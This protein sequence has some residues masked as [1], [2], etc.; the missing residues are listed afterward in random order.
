MT[1]DSHAPQLAGSEK[2]PEGRTPWSPRPVRSVGAKASTM[3]S[4]A[5]SVIQTVRVGA[6]GGRLPHTTPTSGGVKPAKGRG[7][8]FALRGRASSSRKVR[9]SWHTSSTPT[10]NPS[11]LLVGKS[12]S[13]GDRA[14]S[15]SLVAKVRYFFSTRRDLTFICPRV[16]RTTMGAGGT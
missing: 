1:T 15:R 2:T 11:Y 6:T 4:G 10:P 14:T 5:L 3:L 9:W 13:T 16:N 8:Y 12:S 7:G